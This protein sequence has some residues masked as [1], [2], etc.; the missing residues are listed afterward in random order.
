MPADHQ[1][2]AMVVSLHAVDPLGVSYTNTGSV[3]TSVRE[4][5]GG[6]PAVM[7][8]CSADAAAVDD[9]DDGGGSATPPKLACQPLVHHC[10]MVTATATA[11]IT[12]TITISSLPPP[13]S[14]SP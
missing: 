14:P 10:P 6:V 1:S 7:M 8:P 3:W 4:T 11:T 12:I 5:P 13:P 2:T 9:D